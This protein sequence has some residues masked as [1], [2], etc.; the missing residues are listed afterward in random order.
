[1]CYLNMWNNLSF[2]PEFACVNVFPGLSPTDLSDPVVF[3]EVSWWTPHLGKY[4]SRLERN[5]S[6]VYWEPP[7]F[8]SLYSHFFSAACVWS[9]SS[10]KYLHKELPVRIAHRIKGFRSLPFII[11]CNP[12]I[13]QVVRTQSGNIHMCT[14]VAAAQS[15]RFNKKKHG[16]C[17]GGM[18]LNLDLVLT[19]YYHF[20]WLEF[21]CSSL[22]SVQSSM[23]ELVAQRSSSLNLCQNLPLCF[24]YRVWCDWFPS[25]FRLWPVTDTEVDFH[26]D[27]SSLGGHFRL[28]TDLFKEQAQTLPGKTHCSWMFQVPFEQTEFL[29]SGVSKFSLP[30]RCLRT[31]CTAQG[32][33]EMTPKSGSTYL[34]YWFSESACKASVWEHTSLFL[35]YP[36]VSSQTIHCR[37]TFTQILP[38]LELLSS[39][40]S[41]T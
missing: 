12:T 30:H 9:Q 5:A 1:M 22:A 32:H 19:V 20:S 3:W 40:V 2:E 34:A 4:Y 15:H 8:P 27:G 41:I 37:W 29:Q 14:A 23:F 16:S 35:F 36:A 28:S 31:I 7:Q 39:S 17:T 6:C 10:A 33:I 13:L 11:G 21:R 18:W 38:F 24:H 26:G 25:V